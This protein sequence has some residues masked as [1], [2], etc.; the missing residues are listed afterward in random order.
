MKKRGL[1][2]AAGLLLVEVSILM[3]KAERRRLRALREL[4]EMEKIHP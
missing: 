1:L 3:D 2:L 4:E